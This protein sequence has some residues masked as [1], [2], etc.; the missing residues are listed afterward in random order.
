MFSDFLFVFY[1][2]LSLFTL[3]LLFF[4]LTSF[5]FPRFWDHGYPFAKILGLI[6]LSYLAFFFSFLHVLPFFQESLFL[7]LLL[8]LA[9]NWYFFSRFPERRKHLFEIFKKSWRRF[10]LLESIFF[11]ALLFWS[12]IRAHAPDIEGLEKFMDW[13][14]VNSLLRT[15][16]MPPRDMWFAGGFIN[17]YYF[18]HLFTAVLTRLTGLDS[19][20]TYNL[21]IATA[22]AFTFTLGLSFSTAL[23]HSLFKKTKDLLIQKNS[24][25]FALAAGVISALFLSL[26]GNLHPLYKLSL[27]YRE[28]GSLP[29]AASRY[30][31]P[32]A[33]R[34]IGFDPETTDKT[35][36]EFPLYSFVVADLH[37]H[38]ND[39]PVVIFFLASLFS[40]LSLFLD[41][42]K[43]DKPKN[44]PLSFSLLFGFIL[45][46][47]Y[48][49]NAW[50][51]AIYGLF[52]AIFLFFLFL[53][54]PLPFSFSKLFRQVIL[55]GLT[56]LF[57]WLVFVTPF[58]LNFTPLG[59]GVKL[60]DTHTP[61][62]QLFVLHGGFWLL[63]LN[64]P[65]FLFLRRQKK[66]SP[67]L[68]L[69]DYFVLSSIVLATLLIIIPEL[70]Y[71]KDIYIFEHRRANTMFK[72]VY[73]SFLIYALI[74]GYLVVRLNQALKKERKFLPLRLL[75]SSVFLLVFIGQLIYPFFAIKSYYGNLKNYQGL[76]GLN[77]LKQR[78][79]DNYELVNWFQKNIKGQPV[80]LEAA[81]DS[82]TDF[83]HISAATGLPTIEGWLVHEWLWRGGW[84]EPGARSEEV[85]Q[86][87]EAKAPEEARSILQKYQVKYLILGPK[88]REKYENINEEVIEQFAAPLLS[89]GDTN[90][91]QVF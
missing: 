47:M 61:F 49:T 66:A 22:L 40:L 80:I 9:A 91:Y 70:V 65:L 83:N 11:L 77:F 69:S 81:G 76:Y 57:F 74:S 31:Y 34:F 52:F 89:F 62:Y 27:L 16:W 75:V 82:Y 29:A 51:F 13:G 10:L 8:I 56:T 41:P 2:W 68:A 48:M 30:W 17:Y 12:F 42:K 46:I 55:P 18:G 79:P 45:A 4:P 78:Y 59:E 72:L 44:P 35:I 26:G 14:F 5:L 43:P 21:A 37:G 58:S 33:T 19:A 6:V 84:D 85:R 24:L 15:T 20:I 67:P 71:L 64:F 86:I 36:H 3:G 32:D 23:A 90:V 87:Y 73:Q 38:M 54:C 50:D 1:W 7:L 63:C 28:T 39:I 88:E 25:K 60:S 53:R